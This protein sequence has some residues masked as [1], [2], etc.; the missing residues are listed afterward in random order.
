MYYIFE[1]TYAGYICCVFEAFSRK[2]IDARPTR[3]DLIQTTLFFESRPI[4]THPERF[5]RVVQALEKKIGHAGMKLFYQNFLADEEKAWLNGFQLLIKLFQTE[6]LDLKNY[7]DPQILQFHQTIKKVNRERHRMKAFVRFMKDANE[8]YTAIIEPD[9]NVLPLIIDFFRNRYADQQWLIYDIRRQY[10]YHYNLKE[11]QEVFSTAE[12][13][14]DESQS[15]QVSL[16]LKEEEYQ[17][18]WKKYFKSTNIEQRKNLKLH[19]RH[20]PQR[21]WKYLT[22][23]S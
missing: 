11:V 22:E 4:E 23:K 20:V 21:Y 9:F 14:T 12:M 16:D 1:G 8:L 17:I 2:E 19:I 15:L 18:L 13:L 10:G 5:Q 3:L 6:T 7:G